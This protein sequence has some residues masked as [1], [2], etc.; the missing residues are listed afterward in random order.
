[1]TWF[2]IKTLAPKLYWVPD[3]QSTGPDP[4]SICTRYSGC[5]TD[6]MVPMYSVCVGFKSFRNS[7][8]G[9]V[10]ADTLHGNCFI[11]LFV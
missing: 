4:P 11:D 2:A 3:V 10:T 8:K 6:V 9:L 5:F 7:N 1:M